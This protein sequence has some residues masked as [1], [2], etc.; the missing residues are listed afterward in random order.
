MNTELKINGYAKEV[1]KWRTGHGFITPAHINSEG[2]RDLMLGKLMLV[3]TEV[4]EAAEAVRHNDLPN[5]VEE[6]ADSFIRLMDISAAMD[7]DIEAAII[8][9]MAANRLRPIKHGKHCSL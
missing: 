9:K 3:V 6:I 5:F 8:E 4:S 2:A 1:E 7:I